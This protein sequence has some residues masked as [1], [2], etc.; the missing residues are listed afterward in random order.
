MRIKEFDK[1][2]DVNVF[3]IRLP[4]GRKSKKSNNK[5]RGLSIIRLTFLLN[6]NL[7]LYHQHL[8]RQLYSCSEI[9]KNQTMFPDPRNRKIFDRKCRKRT[10][11]NDI[12]RYL[13]CLLFKTRGTISNI[14]DLFDK[15]QH[16]ENVSAGKALTF[17]RSIRYRIGLKGQK[18]N[19]KIHLSVFIQCRIRKHYQLD[20]L[21]QDLDH[22]LS[23][24]K[25]FSGNQMISI[26][27]GIRS[28]TAG[29]GQSF[30]LLLNFLETRTKLFSNYRV[31]H[32]HEIIIQD[33]SNH[34]SN[35]QRIFHTFNF[36]HHTCSSMP[37]I[38]WLK[39]QKRI[40]YQ[41]LLSIF[42]LSLPQN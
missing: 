37:Q 27:H 21:H 1:V 9:F 26:F 7:E 30:H 36:F 12:Y 39:L 22:Q 4:I 40:H 10:V 41:L 28:Y 11:D 13:V 31:T 19:K 32:F 38:G 29:K 20:F 23:N 34:T 14:K 8:S 33:N 42:Q 16:V 15:V 18:S 25:N 24:Y 35:F 2:F 17:F 6:H 5:K 3:S